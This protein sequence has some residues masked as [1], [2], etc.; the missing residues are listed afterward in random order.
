MLN[1]ITLRN[2]IRSAGAS[3][4]YLP[5]HTN[6]KI[7][8]WMDTCVQVFNQENTSTAF[9]TG[10]YRAQR[11]KFNRL[12]TRKNLK[13]TGFN[14]LGYFNLRGKRSTHS[15]HSIYGEGVQVNFL[16]SI[17]R[18]LFSTKILTNNLKVGVL[19]ANIIKL[20]RNSKNKDGRYG[21]LIQ[22]ISSVDLLILAYLII[23]GKKGISAKGI[24]PETLDGI[25]IEYINKIA[26]ELKS[27][28]FNFS[29]V[30]RIYIPKPGKTV[31]RPLG[32]SHPRQ[33][34][35]QK[36]MELVLSTIFEEKFLDCSHGSRPGRS[37]H[38]AL[39]RLQFT[40]GNVSTYTFCIE[41]DIKSC[42][43]NM[44]HAEII[45]GINRE[46]DC[47]STTNLVKKI[48]SAGYILDKDLKKHGKKNAKIYKSN[49]GIPQGLVLSPLF[50]NI[51]L[52][53]LDTYICKE[54]YKEFHKG[55]LR[56]A[57][58]KYRQLR[59]QIKK[60]KN[61][62]I[63]RKLINK[64][65][66]IPSKD[67][68]DPNFKRIFYTRYVDDWVLFVAGTMEDAKT[69]RSKVSNK[70][71]ALGL[72]LNLE[73]THIT[74][75]RK[76]VCHYL[77][78]DFLIRKNTKE[79]FK[80]VKVVKKNNTSI[81]QR[82]TPRLILKAP[83]LKLLIKLKE[84]RFIK[85]SSLGEFFPKGKPGLTPLTHPQIL[86]YFNSR[87]RGI[88]N[89]Y[90]CVHNRNELWSIVRFLK[91]SCALTL[92]RKFKLKTLAKTFKKFGPQ[93][94]FEN[95]AGKIYKIYEPKNLK[96][97]PIDKRFKTGQ[98]LNI[99]ELLTKTWSNSL[100]L[101]Q[102]DEPCALCGTIDDL[103]IHHIRSVKDVRLKTRTYA[104][105]AGGFL[106]KSIPLC[107]DHH[108]KLHSG[109]LSKDEI[110]ILSSYR[111][112]SPGH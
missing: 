17:H 34:I 91:Y 64:S 71:Q 33:K 79:H 8:M 44:P 87:I 82:V 101:S 111:G 13:T 4:P 83:I 107:K 84:K 52:H 68:N 40:V 78:V 47:P 69:I 109:K 81:R 55:K 9:H 76:G 61:L 45:K 32:I 72:T 98:N 77:G 57:N 23:K 62:K 90:C 25:N 5:M 106:R 99:D 35:V 50:S 66:W 28:T 31:P 110:N 42:F 51:V 22:I 36:S 37:C 30:R 112:K 58:L 103:E 74:S 15:T 14:P 104:Q 70:L 49:I 3:L 2:L 38:S 88:L 56:K 39:K 102:F 93:L 27:G 54:L 96:M 92:A 67:V 73:K 10:I 94:K 48:L 89:Y 20:V 59:Y 1:K 24:T 86:N 21:N 7:A 6:D 63:R 41:G 16:A 105:W 100:T 65:L 26:F 12:K 18:R 75:L 108:V 80:P 29:P 53:E 60:E 19:T 95:K 46:V 85:R 11:S 43:D 97:L